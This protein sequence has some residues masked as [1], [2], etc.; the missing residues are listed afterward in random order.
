MK[1]NQILGLLLAVVL[2]LAGCGSSAEIKVD[3]L[4][5]LADGAATY[6]IVSDFSESYYNVE[7]LKMMA[8]KEVDAYGTG[9]HITGAEVANGV[10]NFQYTFD[11]LSH[12]AKFME[13]SCYKSTVAN[14]LTN[15]YKADTKLTSAK[16]SGSTVSMNDESIRTRN[17]FVWNESVAVRCDGNVLYYSENLSMINKTDVQPKEG[18]VGP[19]YVVCK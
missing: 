18:S 11:A 2:V 8:Q 19:Y 6:T 4:S 13:T 17:L 10:L 3:T 1:K 15:G 7:E 5:I 14:A 9:V 12:Y 16:N